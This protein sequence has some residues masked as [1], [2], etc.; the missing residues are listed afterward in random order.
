MSRSCSLVDCGVDREN[1][2]SKLSTKSLQQ[3][4][5]NA[6]FA[7]LLASCSLVPDPTFPVKEGEQAS[8]VESGIEIVKVTP[9]TIERFTN[10]IIKT[11]TSPPS[12][13]RDLA[14]RL[15]VGDVIRVIVW[16]HPEL[17]DPI[18]EQGSTTLS[19]LTLRADGNIF[20][21]YVGE[22]SAGG[23]TTA[24]V[25]KELAERLS[26]VI[27]NP[28]VEVLIL[29]HN[30]QK[31]LVAGSVVDAGPVTLTDVPVTLLE[32]ISA[33]GGFTETAD[34]ETITLERGKFLHVLDG[35]AF[36][37]EKDNQQNP[38]LRDGDVIRVQ[39]R[40]TKHAYVLGQVGSP[41]MVDMTQTKV[42]LSEALA[43]SGW[44]EDGLADARGVFVFREDLGKTIVAQLDLSSPVAVLLGNRF[45][46]HPNDVI[47]V[48][49]S[50]VSQWNTL[51][52]QILPTVG[53]Y[54][55]AGDVNE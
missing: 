30:S 34:I 6:S 5:L 44:L 17:T 19:G 8:A 26:A 25:Q 18:G 45:N 36:L 43:S 24:E 46:L 38:I 10:G 52:S 23:R 39:S 41:G 31:V 35:K 33:R 4:I 54:R 13:P 42:S 48:T 53:A 50:P 21:P 16:D 3:F 1:V 55:A 49:K 7:F 15:G 32:A 51:I 22:L 29:A 9:D 37:E 47:F 40:K 14:Y 11:V 12:P 20:F 2:L 27:P 28:Q